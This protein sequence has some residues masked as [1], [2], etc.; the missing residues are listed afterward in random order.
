MHSCSPRS[1]ETMGSLGA[2]SPEEHPEVASMRLALA[3]SWEKSRAAFVSRLPILKDGSEKNILHIGALSLFYFIHSGPVFPMHFPGHCR[4][5]PMPGPVSRKLGLLAE[6]D[7]RASKQKPRS[8]NI[9]A[10]DA[11]LSFVAKEI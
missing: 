10:R 8:W 1:G 5:K 9:E 11:R 3:R 6:A 2:T 7:D 4:M